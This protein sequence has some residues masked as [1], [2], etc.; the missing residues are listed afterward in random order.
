MGLF[1]KVTGGGGGAAPAAFNAG[2]TFGKNSLTQ[3]LGPGLNPIGSLTRGGYGGIFGGGGLGGAIAGAVPTGG[4][5]EWMKPPPPPPKATY[6]TDFDPDSMGLPKYAA[7]AAMDMSGMKA[8]E[9]SALAAPGESPWLKMATAQ[10]GLE[11]ANLLNTTARSAAGQAAGAQAQLAMR[12][13]LRGG[14]SERLAQNAADQALL[15]QADVRN[16]G[17][18]SRA[19]LGVQG[20][21]MRREDIGRLIAGQQAMADRGLSAADMQNKFNMGIFGEKMKGKGAAMT[22]QAIENAGAGGGGVPPWLN[23]LPGGAPTAGLFGGKLPFSIPG[24]G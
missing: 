23:M 4:I 22:A 8:L 2:S 24:M 7:P 10:Q 5:P 21:N 18:L 13:G 14:A 3:P 1:D 9:S 20:E 16:Q 17:A 19:G 15:G 11:E 12:G 6:G